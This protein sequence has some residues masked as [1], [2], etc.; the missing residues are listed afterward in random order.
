MLLSQAS[1]GLDGSRGLR[2]GTGSDTSRCVPMTRQRSFA[3]IRSPIVN[4]DSVNPLTMAG[5]LAVT[6]LQNRA[7]RS[8]TSL[9]GAFSASTG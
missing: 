6:L 2:S 7:D 4:R 1:T 3:Q 8:A 5:R 9:R